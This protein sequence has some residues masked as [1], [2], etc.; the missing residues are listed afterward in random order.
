M[1]R[2][3]IALLIAALFCSSAYSQ[4]NLPPPCDSQITA[5]RQAVERGL[6]IHDALRAPAARL[7]SFSEAWE[8][9]C[10]EAASW[11]LIAKAIRLAQIYELEAGELGFGSS[12]DLMPLL[13]KWQAW[14]TAF[15]ATP[16]NIHYWVGSF[17][18]YQG[19]G[20]RVGCE[21]YLLP[22]DTG[23]ERGVNTLAELS[24]AL[25]ALFDPAKTHPV[26]ELET[27]DWIKQLGLSVAGIHIQ[28]GMAEVTLGGQLRGI[29]ACGDAILE[30]QI[31]QT[32]FQFSDIRRARITDGETNLLEIVDMSDR[33]S[34]AERET[35]IYDREDLDWLRD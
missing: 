9:I 32:V 30:A 8:E 19:R 34:Q 22:V 7:D 28:D 18:N 14:A 23:L 11:A 6:E 21:S 33:R 3:C 12:D 24:L 15:L 10:A 20:I 31:L 4:Q 5:H 26:A 13:D 25:S 29:G 2:V 16:P 27:E 1:L 17:D 35:Y